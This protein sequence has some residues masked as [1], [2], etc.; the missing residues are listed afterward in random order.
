M[1][2]KYAAISRI[3]I[4]SFMAFYQL[5]CSLKCL[6]HGTDMFVFLMYTKLILACNLNLLF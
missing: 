3:T 5:G 6:L 4:F 2:N 1:I